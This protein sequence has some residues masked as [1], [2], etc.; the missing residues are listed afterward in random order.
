M[1]SHVI[2]G[3]GV[4]FRVPSSSVASPRRCPVCGRALKMPAPS[5]E[6][7]AARSPVSRV[8]MGVGLGVT[9]LIV[10]AIAGA[11]YATLGGKPTAE[12]TVVVAP[13]PPIVAVKGAP[14]KAAET[15]I[16]NI[17]RELLPVGPIGG[18]GR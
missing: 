3:C 18:L 1:A 17:E 10:L 6:V 15:D 4:Q 13:S 8:P 11:A 5:G 12:E 16:R 9:A 2:C 14:Q 7:P